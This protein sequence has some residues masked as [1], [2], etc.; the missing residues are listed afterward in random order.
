VSRRRSTLSF[1]TKKQRTRIFP[2]RWIANA[3]SYPAS[4]CLIRA[5][6]M[7]EKEEYGWRYKAYSLGWKYLNAP[8]ERWGT[9]YSINMELW[10]E[11]MSGKS[12][13]DYDEDG[14]PYWEKTGTIDPD[15]YGDENV[16]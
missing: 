1:A 15:Y 3:L 16:K 11:E 14:V 2:L 9:Y 5:V 6:N 13:D 7:D 4:S 10:K 12:W 8:Y